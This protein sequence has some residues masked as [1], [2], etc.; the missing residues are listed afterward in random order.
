MK[1]VLAILYGIDDK[2]SC[3][4]NT[5]IRCESYFDRII[6]I[7]TGGEYTLN[8]L[9][10][11]SCKFDIYDQSF[12]WGDT[13]SPRRFAINLTDK[14]DWILWLDSDE[15]PTKKLLKELN[16]MIISS[17]RKNVYNLRFA[18]ISHHYND[19]GLDEHINSNP[20]N[21]D[22]TDDPHGIM[23]NQSVTF[24]MNRLIKN[25]D[26]FYVY[27]SF[28]GHSQFA[29][30]NDLW[31]YV[32]YGINHYKSEKTSLISVVL[33]TW[34]SQ[35]PNFPKYVD[36]VDYYNSTEYKLHEEFKKIN[37]IQTPNKLIDKLRMNTEFKNILNE[38]YT[39]DIFRKSKFHFKYYSRWIE[40][41]D[42]DHINVDGDYKC[43]LECCKY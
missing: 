2:F 23:F 39:D 24:T 25:V 8:K 4:S 7:N 36:I 31:E 19:N 12:L 17:E 9:K 10:N 26:H 15:C 34:V 20:Y 29:Q 27:S 13:D 30:Y 38:M 28:G 22:Y 3:V 11:I 43:G 41:Y 14:G 5:L 6:V 18:A 40:K 35:C 21:K 1:K 33:H 32:P 16:S 42:C 37:S